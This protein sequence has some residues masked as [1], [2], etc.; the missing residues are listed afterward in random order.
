MLEL[1]SLSRRFGSGD[2]RAGL[3]TVSLR[4]DEG[5][6]VALIGPSGCGKSTLLRLLAGLEEPSTGRALWRGH[7]ITRTR[8]RHGEI[9]VVFQEPR[10]L[11]WFTVRQNV[12]FGLGP[13]PQP[14]EEPLV[15]EVLERVGLT[16]FAAAMPKELSGGMAQRVG[17]ARALVSRPSLVLL[18]E[19]FSALDA[20]NRLRLQNHFLT[21]W[22]GTGRTL[23]LV[24][25]DI[26][27]ALL[28]A[29]RILV[30]SGSPGEIVADYRIALPRPRVRTDAS[31]QHWKERLLADLGLAEVHP[32]ADHVPLI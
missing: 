29:S 8:P 21:L 27:E 16:R 15:D 23:L 3:G 26:D 13:K 31:F 17:I 14:G 7:E 2:T 18:D 25:H 28:F 4:I 32:F 5:E 22:E 19:P 12:R 20:L 30:L 10:L 9:G 11:P 6:I 24:T 1:H